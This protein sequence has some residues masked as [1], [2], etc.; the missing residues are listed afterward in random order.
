[1]K[2]WNDALVPSKASVPIAVHTCDNRAKKAA[3]DSAR[4]ATPAEKAVP[5]NRPRNSF[6]SSSNGCKPDP[7]SAVGA[8]TILRWGPSPQYARIAG[9]PVITPATYESGER[10]PEEEILPRSGTRGV[11]LLFRSAVRHSRSSQRTA[12]GPRI[13]ELARTAIAARA[14]N[15]GIEVV[16]DGSLR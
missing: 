3:S 10:S 5:F 13:R 15:A 12:E 9:L 14:N 6:D 8:D 4:A 2:G 1:M 11:M 7:S 16:A